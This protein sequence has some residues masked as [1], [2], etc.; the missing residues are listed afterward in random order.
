MAKK[1]EPTSRSSRIR[2]GLPGDSW[3]P[4]VSR[5]AERAYD[6]PLAPARAEA[7]QLRR[8]GRL[9][10]AH[11]REKGA[12]KIRARGYDRKRLGLEPV[13][14]AVVRRVVKVGPYKTVNT[15]MSLR[16]PGKHERRREDLV[17]VANALGGARTVAAI[18]AGSGITA[19]V[20]NAKD[21]AKQG[22]N[23]TLEVV[24][25]PSSGRS[26]E[27]KEVAPVKK[28]FDIDDILAS[29]ISKEFEYSLVEI[30][31]KGVGIIDAFK[32]GK[33]VFSG[34]K[35]GQIVDDVVNAGRQGWSEGGF[36]G[37]SDAVGTAWEKAGEQK[38]KAIRE[39]L[40]E[41]A[42]TASKDVDPK[43]AALYA[44]VPA[45]L[46]A[47]AFGAHK[48]WGMG[49]KKA[50]SKMLKYAGY[51]AAGIGGATALGTYAGNTAS[52]R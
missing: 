15:R 9:V 16:R 8:K 7:K 17:A 1:P 10:A 51:G 37:A 44:G 31:K 23:R 3:R 32:T 25:R 2:A 35:G 26:A 40:T 4:Y 13:E 14:K 22:A 49:K 20:S 52:N 43:K 30:S 48:L 21:K 11:R 6:G 41:A 45:A 12:Y 19:M 28:A 34:T 50:K 47:G 18:G 27:E 24:R 39:G 33:K 42:N 38:G 29:S 5:G 36:K 46:G